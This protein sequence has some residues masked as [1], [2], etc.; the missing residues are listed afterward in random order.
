M[1]TGFLPPPTDLRFARR[2]ARYLTSEGYPAK[3]VHAF[4]VEELSVAPFAA[5]LIVSGCIA[6]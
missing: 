6:A 1:K 5:D 2:S 4:L 3:Q